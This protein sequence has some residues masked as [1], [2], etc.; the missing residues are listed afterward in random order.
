VPSIPLAAG[1]QDARRIMYV[2]G[3]AAL[4]DGVYERRPTGRGATSAGPPGPCNAIAPAQISRYSSKHGG[5]TPAE[6]PVKAV[7][8][9]LACLAGL[10]E[11][12]SCSPTGRMARVSVRSSSRSRVYDLSAHDRAPDTLVFGGFADGKP[13]YQ[14]FV[15]G[16]VLLWCQ[17]QLGARGSAPHDEVCE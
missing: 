5:A 11:S 4:S 8:A 10:V 7:Q 2:Y 15:A 3:S 16:L 14:A 12:V 9:I 17:G 6:L 1:L 13:T